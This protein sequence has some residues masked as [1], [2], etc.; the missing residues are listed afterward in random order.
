VYVRSTGP[1]SE[2]LK[3]LEGKGALAWSNPETSEDL[4]A[5]LSRRIDQKDEMKQLSFL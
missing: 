1:P 4:I 2:G 3:A 5:V